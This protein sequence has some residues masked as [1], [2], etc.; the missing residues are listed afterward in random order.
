[1][2]N[3]EHNSIKLEILST[4]FS[5]SKN[6]L[7]SFSVY[8]RTRVSFQEFNKITKDLENKELIQLDGILIILT[9]AGHDYILKNHNSFDKKHKKWRLTPDS[10][11]GPRI[12]KD[13][14]YVPSIRLLD[15]YFKNIID[16]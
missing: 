2:N 16:K 9:P 3:S 15:T 10:M 4:L 14:K 6:K 5:A 13:Y 12:E 8:R 7:D 1:M 11:L